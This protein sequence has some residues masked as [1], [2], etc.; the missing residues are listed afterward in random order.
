[1]IIVNPA[2]LNHP[3]IT[4]IGNCEVVQSYVYVGSTVTNTVGCEDEIRKRCAITR[5]AIDRLK[6]IWCNCKINKAT[7][8]RLIRSLDF[9][10]FL[11]DT[12]TR[13]VRLM[14]CWRQLLRIRCTPHRTNVSILEEFKIKQILSSTVQIRILKYFGYD[15]C[16]KHSM[17]R[18][19]V[20]GQAE[21]KRHAEAHPRVERTSIEL[22][23]KPPS[24]TVPETQMTVIG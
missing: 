2:K 19:V 24:L 6:K 3:D 22:Q 8:V 21:S 13:T 14:W 16:N 17:E 23:H 12:E 18:L 9:P 11:Y 10:I 15:V 1:M 4:V 20:Q 7:K 5:F